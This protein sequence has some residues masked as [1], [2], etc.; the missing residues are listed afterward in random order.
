MV[1]ELLDPMPLESGKEKDPE[2]IVNKIFT[3]NVTTI[4]FVP[5]MLSS[6]LSYVETNNCSDKLR[7]LKYVFASGE[8]LTPSHVQKFYNITKDCKLINLYGP[9]EATIDVSYFDCV[10][11]ENYNAI[12]IG[13]PIDNIKLYVLSDDFEIQPIGITGE[14]GIS[15]VGLARGYI[16]N[17][18]LTK[19]K[20]VKS[21]FEAK[22][23]FI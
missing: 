6:F 1:L 10:P 12:P 18:N 13:K 7:S 5:S 17:S 19:E 11:N 4:H 9:T 23:K 22:E 3:E 15:G 2:Y 20:F 8:A 21:P 16:G 14:L